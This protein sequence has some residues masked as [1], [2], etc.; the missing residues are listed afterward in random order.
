MNRFRPNLVVRGVTPFAE[1]SWQQISI[2]SVTF[3][4]VK[5]CARCKITTID[6]ETT[7]VGK[8]PLATFATFRRTNDGKVVFGQNMLSTG[9]DVIRV[10]DSV[11]IIR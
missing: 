6:Q 7:V 3:D 1:D 2:G 10:G 8:E 4:L 5:S 9:S 11:M